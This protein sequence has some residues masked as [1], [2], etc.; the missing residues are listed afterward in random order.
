MCAICEYLARQQFVC[1]QAVLV[2]RQFCLWQ[3]MIDVCHDFAGYTN[4]LASC[5]HLLDRFYHLNCSFGRVRAEIQ[6]MMA[7]QYMA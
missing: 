3:T 6:Q 4:L 5:V 1:V 2:T 7:S